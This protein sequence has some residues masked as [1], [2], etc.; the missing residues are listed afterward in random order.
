MVTRTFL[1]VYGG[2][3]LPLHFLII[4]VFNF[5]LLNIKVPSKSD[6]KVNIE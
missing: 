1:D 6:L 5:S 4:Y 3:E 2:R